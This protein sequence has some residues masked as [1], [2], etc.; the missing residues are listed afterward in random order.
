MKGAAQVVPRLSLFISRQ[1]GDAPVYLSLEQMSSRNFRIHN[2]NHSRPKK[3][4][5]FVV[6]GDF[7]AGRRE[8]DQV[9][10]TK[11]EVAKLWRE[12]CGKE[13]GMVYF[14]KFC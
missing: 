5:S 8:G 1:P 4:M 10:S 2:N 11:Y 14:K 6:G 9:R 3:N 13:E 12:V 7:E